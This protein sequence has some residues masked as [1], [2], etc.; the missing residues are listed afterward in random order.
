MLS[1]PGRGGLSGPVS[2]PRDYC[3][4]VNKHDRKRSKEIKYD[5]SSQ[6]KPPLCHLPD[7]NYWG[8]AL[9]LNLYRFILG[10]DARA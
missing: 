2:H 4:I 8:Y 6:M 9:Q 7:S 10:P 5:S 3:P 1:C